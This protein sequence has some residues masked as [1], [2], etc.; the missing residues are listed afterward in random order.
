RTAA[1]ARPAATAASVTSCA[2]LVR[3][4]VIATTRGASAAESVLIAA[5]PTRRC[6]GDTDTYLLP[7]TRLLPTPQQSRRAS[8]TGRTFEV[9][10]REQST[11]RVCA[12]LGSWLIASCVG[13][14]VVERPC[15][16]VKNC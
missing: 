11:A 2:R 13:P 5:R 6:L 15:V 16:V 8:K 7:G 12:A 1:S 9:G 10:P 3:A 4:S 14:S